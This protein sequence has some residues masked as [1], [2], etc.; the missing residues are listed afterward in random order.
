MNDKK[1]EPALLP[2]TTRQRHFQ[3]LSNLLDALL[4]PCCL[5]CSGQLEPAAR[6]LCSTCREACFQLS[7]PSC[8]Q[9]GRLLPEGAS[10]QH[11]CG[12]CRLAPPPQHGLRSGY[13]YRSVAPLLARIKRRAETALLV[14]LL[15]HLRDLNEFFPEVDAIVPVPS[16]RLELARRGHEPTLTLGVLLADRLAKPLLPGIL[17]K[18]RSTRPQHELGRGERAQNLR[19][20]FVVPTSLPLSARLLC[21][22]YGLRTGLSPSPLLTRMAANLEKKRTIFNGFKL[23]LVDDVV[24]TGATIAACSRA[25]LR[26]GATSI[27]VFTLAKTLSREECEVRKSDG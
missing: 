22:W 15:D 10:E 24:T 11:R 21:R 19:D 1:P 6:G 25:L 4:P 16:H 18:Q 23:L 2:P 8:R 3:D 20:A 26:G 5:V 9:C 14:P 27:E 13:D 7:G 17:R 12:S